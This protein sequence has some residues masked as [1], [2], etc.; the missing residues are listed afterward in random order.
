MCKFPVPAAAVRPGQV[1]AEMALNPSVLLVPSCFPAYLGQPRCRETGTLMWMSACVSEQELTKHEKDN[2]H[3]Q[4][5]EVY[6][7]FSWLISTNPMNT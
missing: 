4:G 2:H 6:L 7:I 5:V 1:R 3:N